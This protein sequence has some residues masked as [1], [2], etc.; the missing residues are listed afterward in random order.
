[1]KDSKIMCQSYITGK[2]LKC[3]DI[4]GELLSLQYYFNTN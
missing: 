3:A 4:R 2:L 1:M